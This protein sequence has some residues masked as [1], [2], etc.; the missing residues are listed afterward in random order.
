M[1]PAFLLLYPLRRRD[2]RC[3]AGCAVGLVLGLVLI[4]AAVFGPARTLAYYQ[5]WTEV[6]VRPALGTGTDRSRAKEL[7]DV[8]A[9]DEIHA[10]QIR[11]VNAEPVY[12]DIRL[13]GL[14]VFGAL[15]WLLLPHPVGARPSREGR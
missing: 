7:I 1:I 11:P 4:P 12:G 9:R 10:Q 8:T 14:G 3:L 13:S 2:L 5:E 15:I 6:L